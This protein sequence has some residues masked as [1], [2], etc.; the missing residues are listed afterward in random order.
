MWQIFLSH[1][2]NTELVTRLFPSLSKWI[3]KQ[4]YMNLVWLTLVFYSHQKLAR[5]HCRYCWWHE[6]KHVGGLSSV[7]I[8]F[9][10]SRAVGSC[11]FFVWICYRGLLVSCANCFVV[12]L[13]L[14]FVIDF[15][16]YCAYDKSLNCVLIAR[17]RLR[18]HFTLEHGILFTNFYSNFV[19]V[20]TTNSSNNNNNNNCSNGTGNIANITI[21]ASRLSLSKERAEMSN[22]VIFHLCLRH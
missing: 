9:H 11:G 4:G 18:M 10:K 14:C 15:A 2:L 19:N 13:P 12:F 1:F 6:L 22:P 17:L 7:L 20:K 3:L 21:Q 5:C 16:M 8:N